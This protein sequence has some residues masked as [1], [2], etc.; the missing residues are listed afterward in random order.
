MHKVRPDIHASPLA[1]GVVNALFDREMLTR[2]ERLIAARTVQALM[3]NGYKFT[4]EH[5]DN[6]G[7]VRKPSKDVQGTD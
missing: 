4:G 7:E 6:I 1:F 5:N 2:H 3:E